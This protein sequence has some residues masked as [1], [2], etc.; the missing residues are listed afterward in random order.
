MNNPH[1]YETRHIVG[2][3][4]G[5]SSDPSALSVARKRVPFRVEAE[6]ADTPAGRV[7]VRETRRRGP[8]SY[9][10][11][12]LDRFELG[13]PYQEVAERATSVLEAPETGDDP[14]L[15]MDAT[16]VGQAVREMFASV[17][18]VEI[19]FTSG[20]SVSREGRKYG[21]PK[22]DLAT[23]MQSL[24]QGGRLRVAEG[25]PMAGAFA[26]EMKNFRVKYTSAGNARFEH[27]TESDHDDLVL[28]TATALWF[29]ESG[30]PSTE[31]INWQTMDEDDIRL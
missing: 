8:A 25:L 3:D 31:T 2:L 26:Q 1:G 17:N 29:G 7:K 9:D 4:L 13:M 16:G 10:V 28:A 22:K 24:L 27:A 12:H 11:V 14:V 15:V 5:Q 18:P 19:T 6:G 20:S 30:S 21:V 23:E